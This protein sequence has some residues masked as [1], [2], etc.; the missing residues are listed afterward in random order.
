M[1]FYSLI[2]SSIADKLALELQKEMN[3]LE[4]EWAFTILGLASRKK[5]SD[6]LIQMILP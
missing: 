2:D 6:K 4:N 3:N 5:A 1:E